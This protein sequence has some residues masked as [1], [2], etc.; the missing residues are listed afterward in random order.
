MEEISFSPSG[1][2][3]N[4]SKK[5]KAMEIKQDASKETL[6]R[7]A[8]F[9]VGRCEL[10]AIM[11]QDKVFMNGQFS[12]PYFTQL[13]PEEYFHRRNKLHAEWRNVL[14]RFDE[15]RSDCERRIRHCPHGSCRRRCSLFC[16]GS[17]KRQ[18]QRSVKRNSSQD[19][20]ASEVE[21]AG[22]LVD[23]ARTSMGRAMNTGDSKNF[24]PTI[25]KVRIGTL[26]ADA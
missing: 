25:L 9:G 15:H 18:R 4:R 5:G 17:R 3:L 12:R 14:L 23:A 1:K 8:F 26:R 10:N 24:L 20:E 13:R 7:F 21:A 16:S 11:I 2:D 22:E 6:P 19:A